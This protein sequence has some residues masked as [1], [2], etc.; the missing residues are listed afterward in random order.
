MYV[1]RQPMVKD[2]HGEKIYGPYEVGYYYTKNDYTGNSQTYW[3]C[4]SKWAT[5]KAASAQ[6]SYLNG[7]QPNQHQDDQI[8]PETTKQQ[9]KILQAQLAAVPDL[10]PETTYTPNH[11]FDHIQE[12]LDQ[13][14][15]QMKK[16]AE[17][18]KNNYRDDPTEPINVDIDGETIE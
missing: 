15:D 17:A 7:G 18:I 8:T 14:Y 12:N 1:Y 10:E 16:Q 4:E 6:T 9:Q 2:R 11:N 5:N 13:K 3:Y